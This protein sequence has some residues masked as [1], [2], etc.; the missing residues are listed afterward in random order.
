MKE[1]KEMNTK[2]INVVVGVNRNYIKPMSIMLISLLENNKEWRINF[3]IF[4][5]DFKEEDKEDLLKR[6]NK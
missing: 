4:Q 2:E 5:D 6:F 1:T 3:N